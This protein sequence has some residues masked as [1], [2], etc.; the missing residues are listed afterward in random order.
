MFAFVLLILGISFTPLDEEPIGYHFDQ[1]KVATTIKFVSYRN[2]IIIPVQ[3]NDTIKLNLVLD[4]GT[5]SL[6][7]FGNKCRRL[8]NI[9]KGRK[10]KI[11]GRGNSEFVDAD[12]SF[13]NNIKI[14]DIVGKGVGAVVLSESK[15]TEVAPG[16]DGI[17]GYELFIRFCI[18]VDYAKRTITLFDEIPSDA[19][20]KFQPM[21]LSLVDSRPEII[22]TIYLS[23]RKKIFAKTLIDT[24]SSMG[25]LVF[26]NRKN[27]FN[28][29]GREME[30]GIGLA[31]SVMGFDL[32]ISSWQLGNITFSPGNCNLVPTDTEGES[33]ISASIG[34]GFL[35]DHVV[36]FHYP[37]SQFFIRD[38]ES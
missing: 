34:G 18:K 7:L 14:G 32:G 9:A 28:V 1:G 17:I 37:S 4:T 12:F 33:T 21:A 25:L 3:L 36:M 10:V 22:S 20:E 19:Y 8:G 16:I 35:K 31:G 24:G 38:K 23:K 29:F 27:N 11:G 13:P 15:L 6:I 5:R 2:L 30:L 26:A